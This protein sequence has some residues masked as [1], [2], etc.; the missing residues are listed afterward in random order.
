MDTT[1][2]F[3]LIDFD[4]FLHGT[5]GDRQNVAVAVDTALSVTGFMYLK[6]HGIDQSKVEECFRLVGGIAISRT[7]PRS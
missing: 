3:P 7:E 6:N 2:G 4:S 5:A 1:N